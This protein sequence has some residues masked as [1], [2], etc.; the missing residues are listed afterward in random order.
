M[1]GDKGS[2]GGRA[3]GTGDLL[4]GKVAS[5]HASPPLQ[6]LPRSVLQVRATPAAELANRLS[7]EAMLPT[8]GEPKRT[9]RNA[10]RGTPAGPAVSEWLVSVKGGE[11]NCSAEQ[12]MDCV[13]SAV[14]EKSREPMNV[15][16]DFFCM[17]WCS[18]ACWGNMR[19]L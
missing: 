4:Q 1:A 11:G 14:I 2:G 5:V 18:R 12:P 6:H 15:R 9:H 19:S 13:T 10:R 3:C 17:V 16:S 7:A 8:R